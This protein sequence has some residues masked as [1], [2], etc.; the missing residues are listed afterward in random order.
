MNDGNG[1]VP[2]GK[3]SDTTI[4][5]ELKNR[6]TFAVTDNEQRWETHLVGGRALYTQILTYPSTIIQ[7][8]I[9]RPDLAKKKKSEDKSFWFNGA[10]AY[11]FAD[12]WLFQGVG[13]QVVRSVT[14][15]HAKHENYTTARDAADRLIGLATAAEAQDDA[16]SLSA[17]IRAGRQ[18]VLS[19]LFQHSQEAGRVLEQFVSGKLPITPSNMTRLN[20]VFA[21]LAE[22]SH[23]RAE[24]LEEYAAL[25]QRPAPKEGHKPADYIREVVQKPALDSLR[26]AQVFLGFT[27]SLLAESAIPF[28]SEIY[29]PQ[30]EVFL[31]PEQNK[32][33]ARTISKRMDEL[34]YELDDEGIL[35]KREGVTGRREPTQQDILAFANELHGTLM[36]S[37][38][39]DINRLLDFADA[40]FLDIENNIAH[41]Q[42]AQAAT[43]VERAPEITVT[44][45]RERVQPQQEETRQD[46]TKESSH[47]LRD[48][49]NLPRAEA[50]FLIRKHMGKEINKLYGRGLSN[51]IIAFPVNVLEEVLRN[52][53][54]SS[55]AGQPR[56]G[57]DAMI[58]R[59]QGRDTE[60]TRLFDTE[61]F[62]NNLLSSAYRT[63]M[64]PIIASY[65]TVALQEGVRLNS[66][67]A[68][69]SSKRVSPIMAAAIRAGQPHV[70]GFTERL[71]QATGPHPAVSMLMRHPDYAERIP[72]LLGGNGGNPLQAADYRLLERFFFDMS[73]ATVS[74]AE[75]VLSPFQPGNGKQP[76]QSMDQVAERIFRKPID[77][78]ADAMIAL[79]FAE[80]FIQLSRDKI[81]MIEYVDPDGIMIKPEGLKKLSYFIA[82]ESKRLGLKPSGEKGAE[83]LTKDGKP[84]PPETLVAFSQS[85]LNRLDACVSIPYLL[86]HMKGETR[87]AVV[88]QMEQQLFNGAVFQTAG[89]QTQADAPAQPAAAEP[90][91]EKVKRP[92]SGLL[93][94]VASR[95]KHPEVSH[96]RQKL[97][98]R[99]NGSK[100]IAAFSSVIYKSLQH[101]TK[102]L[103]RGNLAVATWTY[104]AHPILY[105]KGLVQVREVWEE[106]LF[107]KRSTLNDANHAVD[108]AGGA[109]E[110]AGA[111]DPALKD[112]LAEFSASNLYLDTL[113]AEAQYQDIARRASKPRAERTEEDHRVMEAYYEKSG[114]KLLQVAGKMLSS[115]GGETRRETFNE[116]ITR[117]TSQPVDNL[118]DAVIGLGF[119][120]GAIHQN[121]VALDKMTY[122]DPK[123]IMLDRKALQSLGGYMA[124]QAHAAGFE[125]RD[126]KLLGKDGNPPPQ[127]DI[128]RYANVAL[129]RFR[130]IMAQKPKLAGKFAEQLAD[131]RQALAQQSK[132]VAFGHSL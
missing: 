17:E 39:T 130:D 109:I 30:D 59:M 41:Q 36:K 25:A 35:Y 55:V 112:R 50:K 44:A 120:A 72:Q 32:D 57:F 85:V 60:M 11:N 61:A 114:D 3:R 54:K 2:S 24:M 83:M 100:L 21:G 6:L 29:I 62:R 117:I 46:K 18:S 113:E 87:D 123:E 64:Q 16:P 14:T 95:W 115:L 131:A 119:L 19:E 86:Y 49:L 33:L 52:F 70:P 82:E 90:W 111:A 107:K 124:D 10:A 132:Q 127:E 31:T 53:F 9:L 23:R 69:D 94:N 93:S 67:L 75:E 20:T 43:R 63:V 129:G 78:V 92:K 22:M 79:A 26:D 108:L 12:K 56:A 65:G 122:V 51:Q 27:A 96:E 103:D 7:N 101:E 76:L 37:K 8:A 66:A 110:A 118:A 77:N 126:D 42:A 40:R 102:K 71:Q 84:V 97:H 89:R 98:D 4:W 99:L 104:F 91:S 105:G 88:T 106:M 128:I 73:R 5:E 68:V 121:A 34:G 13:G 47:F 28:S 1:I 48:A 80:S 38:G 45:R 74:M 58:D 81:E 125:L 15:G 116:A